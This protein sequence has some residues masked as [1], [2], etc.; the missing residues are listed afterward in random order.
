VCSLRCF[1]SAAI[2]SFPPTETLDISHLLPVPSLHFTTHFTPFSRPIRATRT[3]RS[4]GVPIVCHPT[5]RNAFSSSEYSLHLDLP[6]RS[7]VDANPRRRLSASVFIP[8]RNQGYRLHSPMIFPNQTRGG[9]RISWLKAYFEQ[10]E[11]CQQ[12]GKLLL[13][14]L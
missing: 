1:P 7:F 4:Q 8:K 11:S 14:W 9:C 13:L 10:E 3:R 5:W 12:A 6:R 2:L